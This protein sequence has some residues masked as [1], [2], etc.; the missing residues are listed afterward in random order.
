MELASALVE[1]ADE[2]M[3]IIIFDYIR[4]S[5][6]AIDETDQCKA[7]YVL[8][9]MLKEHSWF[10]SARTDDLIDL[11]LSI[12][13]PADLEILKY[14]FLC[15]QYLLVNLLKSKGEKIYMKAFLVLNEI[16]LTLKSKKESRK[17]AYDLL[18]NMSSSLKN[19][20]SSIE[21]SNLERLFYMIMGYLSSPSP[22]IM[23][24]AV[25]ALSLLIYNN[26]VFC[27]A[28]PNLVTSVLALLQ[29]KDNEVIK[30][31]LGFVKVLV[32]TLQSNDLP[33]I[34][35]D[36]VDAIL[37]W[38]SVS[39]HHF[40]SKVGIILEILMRKC[41][42]DAVDT[43]TPTKY[44]GFVKNIT[45]ARES[46]KHPREKSK[47]DAPQE[48]ADSKADRFRERRAR[49]D[50]PG[51]FAKKSRVHKIQKY[52]PWKKHQKVNSGITDSNQAAAKG[53]R[54]QSLDRADSSTSEIHS[55]DKASRLNKN[56]KR[57][58]NEYPGQRYNDKR[59]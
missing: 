57:K 4:P 7:Y 18:L 15:F 54:S 27:L 51:S 9:T 22:H 33:K 44:K 21:E 55:G 36:I 28:M 58:P 48:S 43:I 39:K 45:E 29:N 17:L 31:T 25:S 34:L 50:T 59:N 47:L 35:P 20:E 37:P 53:S 3:I 52:K 23:S 2:D 32:S 5:L 49:P 41:G 12:K 19:S 8:S 6:L 14:R 10:C 1:A 16:I 30:A 26:P 38:S 11:L 46:R 42:Y 24:G 40:R 56:R 13:E